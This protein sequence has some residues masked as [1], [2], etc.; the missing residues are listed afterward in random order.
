MGRSVRCTAAAVVLVAVGMVFAG[1]ALAAAPGND[2][3][4]APRLVGALPYQN[5]VNTAE[6]TV[7]A[8]DPGC[9]SDTNTVWYKFTP[10]QTARYQFQTT[11]QAIY[12]AT[13]GFS[14]S[15]TVTTGPRSALQAIDCTPWGVTRDDLQAGTTYRIMIGTPFGADYGSPGGLV[16][17]N[18]TKP[19]LPRVTGFA[20]TEGT[21]NRNSGIA[22]VSGS[23][24]CGG[25]AISYGVHVE[26][27]QRKSTGNIAYA[28]G[29][30]GGSCT[31]GV[32]N[33]WIVTLDPIQSGNGIG[34]TT[35]TAAL[36]NSYGYACD[37]YDCAQSDTIST[38]IHL[39][40]G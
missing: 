22:T 36:T 31:A 10:S 7:A 24:I 1:P 23:L 13:G 37:T 5:T 15:I 8:D 20:I 34:F 18:V 38:E 3:F 39:H 4:G 32:T 19:V 25:G 14:P 11:S 35:G 16:T 9:F 33:H 29:D 6:A 40:R 12:V 28:Y 30:T 21:V 26:L 17:F 27:R 2:G